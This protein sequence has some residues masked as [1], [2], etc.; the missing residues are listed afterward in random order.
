MCDPLATAA[1]VSAALGDNPLR[2]MTGRGG[3]GGG[4]GRPG[5][6][7]H[8]APPRGSG[9]KGA[10]V[11]HRGG[12]GRPPGVQPNRQA[13]GGVQPNRQSGGGG[14]Q[15]NRQSGGGGALRGGTSGGGRALLG[16]SRGAKGALLGGISRGGSI[17]T[18]GMGD[19]YG[20]EFSDVQGAIETAFRVHAGQLS[21]FDYAQGRNLFGNVVDAYGDWSAKAAAMSAFFYGP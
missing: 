15:P 20:D 7:T 11:P 16:G 3:G 4:G 6:R 21:P 10:P 1:A 2:F 13:G 9:H 19:V 18:G 14:V 8:N 12:G 5:G 17:M